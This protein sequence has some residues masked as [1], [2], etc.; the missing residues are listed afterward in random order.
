MLKKNVM[1]A[2]KK[3]ERRNGNNEVSPSGYFIYVKIQ[4]A[5]VIIDVLEYVD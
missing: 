4:K 3:L 2:P 5:D 1:A